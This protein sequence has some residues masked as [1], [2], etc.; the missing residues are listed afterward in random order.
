MRGFILSFLF[1]LSIVL[2]GCSTQ[3][4]A[5]LLVGKNQVSVQKASQWKLISANSGQATTLWPDSTVAYRK[6]QLSNVIATGSI[7]TATI[8]CK[9]D[10]LGTLQMRVQLDPQKHSIKKL[11]L[12]YFGNSSKH[13][14]KQIGDGVGHYDQEN[15]RYYFNVAYQTISELPGN[16][17]FF[18]DLYEIKG[19]ISTET[20]TATLQPITLAP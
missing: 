17:R 20:T 13:K 15:Q 12:L 19:W 11:Q 14:V 4:S 6:V 16:R 3:A 18:S 7:Y 2:I 9:Q 5:G 10:S 1:G 8:L